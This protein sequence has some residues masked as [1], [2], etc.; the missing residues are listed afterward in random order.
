MAIPPEALYKDI[1]ELFEV[2]NATSSS[3][4]M[5]T[6]MN[7]DRPRRGVDR[8]YRGVVYVEIYFLWPR[9]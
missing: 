5:M 2:S 3:S 4:P 8:A 7:V 9:H 6:S 1:P